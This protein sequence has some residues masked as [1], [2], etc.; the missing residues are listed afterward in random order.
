MD[1]GMAV[2]QLTYNLFYIKAYLKCSPSCFA[3]ST[4]VNTTQLE[5]PL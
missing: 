2:L 4:Y 5:V 3:W 1:S